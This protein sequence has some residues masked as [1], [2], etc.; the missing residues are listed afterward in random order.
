MSIDGA[1]VSGSLGMIKLLMSKNYKYDVAIPLEKQVKFGEDS[2][3]AQAQPIQDKAGAKKKGEAKGKP[4][5]NKKE[6]E[7]KPA[8]NKALV[9]PGQVFNS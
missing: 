1:N 3:P 9:N 5:A 6:A 8:A 2:G 7:K 4:G